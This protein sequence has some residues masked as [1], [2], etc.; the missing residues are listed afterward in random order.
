MYL[1]EGTQESGELTMKD[2]SRIWLFFTTTTLGMVGLLVLLRVDGISTKVVFAAAMAT[3]SPHVLLFRSAWQQPASKLRK[4]FER[5]AAVS[6][7]VLT[8]AH[9]VADRTSFR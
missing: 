6:L 9:F 3:L 7:V 2:E 1:D 4:V 8:V 5:W